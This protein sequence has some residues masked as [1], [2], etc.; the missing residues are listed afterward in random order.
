VGVG[1]ALHAKDGADVAIVML[2]VD[3]AP[4]ASA[5]ASSTGFFAFSLLSELK[6]G[7]CRSTDQSMM[8]AGGRGMGGVY[9]GQ[10]AAAGT[11]E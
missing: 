1:A 8:L 11:G 2:A 5:A 6:L 7:S 10:R 3:F 9:C 4:R